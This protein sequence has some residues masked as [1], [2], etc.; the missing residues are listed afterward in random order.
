VHDWNVAL[1]AI[2]EICRVFSSIYF[3]CDDEITRQVPIG[4]K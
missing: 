4:K 2:R 3:I 1:V